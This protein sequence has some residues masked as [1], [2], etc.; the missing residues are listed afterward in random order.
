[1]VAVAI[2]PVDAKMLDYGGTAG[3]IAG[4][5]FAGTVSAIASREWCLV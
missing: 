3:P 1:M 2:N 5:D 4:S